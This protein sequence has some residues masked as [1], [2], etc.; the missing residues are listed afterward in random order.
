[1]KGFSAND[2]PSHQGAT[3]TWF[4]PK[5]IV[6]ALGGFDLDPCTQSFRP[7]DTALRHI[8][9]D[10]GQCGI[11]QEWSGRVWLNPP[12]GKDV[13][14]W[15]EKLERH[16][17]GIALVFSRTETRWAQRAL[18]KCDGVLFL[19]G[20]ISFIH[21]TGKK[22]HNASNG[23]MLLFYGKDNLKYKKSL[24]GQFLETLTDKT[25]HMSDDVGQLESGFKS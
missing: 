1:M 6:G 4:T 12:Y 20:R 11:E 5:R 16:G 9:Y 3:N 21:E 15:L 18:S 8:E 24:P 7:F 22:S 2:N 14:V 13:G 23:S 25:E 10:R 19:K 17:N